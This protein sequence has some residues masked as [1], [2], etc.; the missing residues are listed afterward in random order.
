M[1]DIWLIFNLM[2]PFILVLVHTYIDTLRNEMV[3]NDGEGREI[4]HHGKSITVIEEREATDG[5]FIKV[6][7]APNEDRNEQ[8]ESNV[9]KSRSHKFT[10]AKRVFELR[11]E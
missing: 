3:V 8:R 2:I 9:S 4:N 10:M 7:P 1:V 5:K 6:S 11:L